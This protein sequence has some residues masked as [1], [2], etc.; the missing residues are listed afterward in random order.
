MK[1]V[2]VHR[3]GNK[4]HQNF[5]VPSLPA[6]Q[7]FDHDGV[8]R[9]LHLSVK[10]T[11]IVPSFHIRWNLYKIEK[12]LK[13]SIF[14]YVTTNPK[15]RIWTE[16]LASPDL[17]LSLTKTK[18]DLRQ[19][20]INMASK[21]NKN[22]KLILAATD[23]WRQKTKTKTKIWDTLILQCPV[24]LSRGKNLDFYALKLFL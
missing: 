10:L 24:Q 12:T 16:L 13:S 3:D 1:A 21:I 20:P 8:C 17:E 11:V 23:H 6:G 19:P 15:W 18:K 22:V 2:M 4:C 5:K 9:C 7:H 14:I